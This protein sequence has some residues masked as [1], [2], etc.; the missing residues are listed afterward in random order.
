VKDIAAEGISALF[1]VVH[2]GIKMV[3]HLADKM[4]KDT[5]IKKSCGCAAA[6]RCGCHCGC[7]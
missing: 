2:G 1:K 4:H 5:C 6:P 3:E 7:K